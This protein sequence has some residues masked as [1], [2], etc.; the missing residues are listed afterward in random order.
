MRAASLVLALSASAALAACGSNSAGK[1]VCD[2]T[3][4]PPAACMSQCD[5][6]PSAANTCPSGYHCAADGFCDALCTPGGSECGDGYVCTA[7]GRCRGE[8]E[9][10]GIECN[11]TECQQMGMPETSISGT[12]YA[13]NGTLPLYGITVYIPSQQLPPLTEGAQ[14]SRCN[15]DL[16]GVPLARATTDESGK[17]T[18]QGNVPDGAN[19]PLVITSGKWRRQITIPN[20]TKC[21]D[22]ALTDAQ[23]TR[24]PKN[25]SEGDIPRIALSTGG[26]DA[27]EC[28]IR[29]M[30]IEDSEIGKEGTDQRIHLYTNTMSGG[31]GVDQ[32][33][34]G[35]PGGTGSFTDSQG[36]WNSDTNLKKYDIVI[37]S[38]EGDHYEGTK[39][40]TAMNAMEQYTA[41]G[42]RVFMSHWH[43]I[44]IGGGFRSGDAQPQ[45]AAWNGIANWNRNDSS[46]TGVDLIDTVNNP[47]GQSFATWMVK[48]GGRMTPGVIAIND[49]HD[50]SST[51]DMARAERW[52]YTQNGNYPQNFQFTTPQNVAADQRCG[53][54]VF[55]DMHVSGNGGD[56]GDMFPT[57]PC[58][59]TPPRALSAQEKALAFM[60]FD[61]AS[62]VGVIF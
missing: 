35:F 60:L 51:M 15:D 58:G 62:C 29:R 26:A 5:P 7:D 3:V 45:I 10:Q 8:D 28:I 32:F 30:G 14:C 21:G 61:L 55:S 12:V 27:L 53:K 25:R 36:L 9:C 47:K 23:Q 49:F 11:I 37:L 6:S 48:V 13:P 38:C 20:V 24:L 43:N 39:T 22:T 52:T 1:S 42:G 41:V 57:Q 18:I 17:F 50:T 19:I 4:P 40:Q 44:W 34:A 59:D 54:V 56:P 46:A 33:A 16:P 2:N 31:E